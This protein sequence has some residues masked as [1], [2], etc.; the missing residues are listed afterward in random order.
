[1]SGSPAPPFV[2]HPLRPWHALQ[3]QGSGRPTINRL[4]H[5][6]TSL[7]LTSA[8]HQQRE[9]VLVVVVVVIGFGD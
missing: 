6:T 4:A 9:V 8:I 7:P 2:A 1:M 5:F 3:G